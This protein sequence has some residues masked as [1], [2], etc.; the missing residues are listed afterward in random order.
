M[1]AWKSY[2]Q[3][4][5]C[6]LFLAGCSD[7]GVPLPFVKEDPEDQE[8]SLRAKVR[9]FKEGNLVDN[10]G[11]HPHFNQSRTLLCED[12]SLGAT[13]EEG[14]DKGGTSDES[15][16]GDNRTPR[17]NASM[18]SGLARCFQPMDR[19][20]D[21]FEDRGDDVNRPYL[22]TLLFQKNGEGHYFFRD[23][24][25]F[26]V[27]NGKSYSKAKSG[28]PDPFG[29]LQTGAKDEVDLTQ[30]NYGFTLEAHGEFKYQ[31]GKGQFIKVTGDDDLWI[32]IDDKRVLDL[33]GM[34]PAQEGEVSLDG[35]GLSDGAVYPVDF[36]FAERS[37]AS[38]KLAI[39]TNF[40]IHAGK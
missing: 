2:G 29:H 12:R 17:L 5:L 15:F 9:D 27:D 4:F 31:S 38:S 14:L 24:R 37:V 18:A 36:Y 11:T 40:K 6:G 16:P 34:H 35:L 1:S 10:S 13:V 32:F 33:G 25:F 22:I 30:H 26:P 3:L 28:V 19:F 7:M 8:F 21:W 23:D 20:G 39:Y